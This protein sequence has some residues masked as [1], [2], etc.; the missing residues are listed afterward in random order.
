MNRTQRI[1]G[2]REG[3]RKSGSSSVSGVGVPGTHKKKDKKIQVYN[4]EERGKRGLQMAAICDSSVSSALSI[5][6]L[7][8]GAERLSCPP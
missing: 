1:R 3:V 7:L 4:H 2:E 6:E 8:V 5:S